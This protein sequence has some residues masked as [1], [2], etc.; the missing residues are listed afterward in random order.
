MAK[1][2]VVEDDPVLLYPLERALTK[3]GHSVESASLGRD[4][5]Q[6]LAA[7]KFDI[8]ILDWSL[9]DLSGFEVLKKFR[10]AGGITP[11]IFLTG[12]DDVSSKKSALDAGADDYLSKPFQAEEL[13]ARIRAVLRRPVG[14]MP[15]SVTIG[16]L[17][18]ELETRNV[19]VEGV[20]V[21]LGKKEY[22]VLELLMRHPNRRFSAR[23]IMES[24][25]PSDT[26]SSEEAVRSCMKQLRSKISDRGGLCII[27]TIPGGGYRVTT[28]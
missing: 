6:M 15:T 18:I 26:G 1:I 16:N 5:L 17:T 9:P 11:A 8:V 20:P 14:L 22:A 7:Y 2:L 12:R 21:Q 19:Y 4:A 3:E 24:V 28:D 27:S 10:S 23:E 13:F 25:W